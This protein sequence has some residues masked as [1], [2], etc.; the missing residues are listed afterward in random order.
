MTMRLDI[1]TNDA[2]ELVRREHARELGAGVVVAIYRLAKLAQLHDLGNQAFIRQLEQTHQIIG[3]Y[4]LRSGSNVSVL[5]AEKATFVAGQLLKGN[6]GAY[7]AAAE[8]GALLERMGGSELHISRDITREDLNAFAEQVSLYHRTGN[9]SQIR[10]PPKMHLRRVADVARLRGIE[11]ESLTPDQR[12]VRAYASAVVIMRRFFEDLSASR[13]VLPRRIKRIAQSLVDLSDAATA[14]YLGVTEVRNANYDEA[15]RAVNTAI[16]AVSIARESTQERTTLAQ[17]AMAAMMH[18]VARPRALAI[19]GAGGAPMPGMAGP[20]T[21][22]EDDEDRLPAG[23]AAV[24]TALGRVNEPSITRTVLTFEA[25]WLR[26]RT[27]LG[28]VYWGARAPTLQ[29]T[30]IAVARRYNDLLTPE[31]GLAPPTTDYAVAVLANELTDAQDRTVLRMLVSALGLLPIG[32]VVQL[33]TGE[34]AEVTRRTKGLGEKACVLVLADANGAPYPQP[35]EVDLAQDTRRTVVRVLSVDGWRKGLE[36]AAQALGPGPESDDDVIISVPPAPMPAVPP[37]PAAP[38]GMSPMSPPLSAGSN[39]SIAQQYADQ[40]ASWGAEEER[41]A[42][43]SGSSVEHP[44]S[45]SMPSLGSSPSAVAEAMGRMINDSLRPPAIPPRETER[46]DRTVFQPKGPDDAPAPR[47]TTSPAREAT[48]RGNL[49]ATPLP[50]VLVYML[51]HALTGT[52]VFERSSRGVSDDMIFFVNGVPAKIRLGE[53]VALLGE[54]LVEDGALEARALDQAVEGARRLGILLGEYLVGHDLVSRE[55]LAWGLEGQLLRKI[56]HVANLAPEI[57]YAYYRDVDLL[58]GWGG[59][60]AVS[61]PL[62][63]IL[64]SVRHWTDRARVRATLN[65]I[66]KHP[67]ALH[68]DSDLTNLAVIAEEQKVLDAVRAEAM[69]LPQL[70]QRSFADDEVVSS[71]VYSL[72]VTRQFA[73]KGQKKGPMAAR[74]AAWRS[75]HPPPGSG[76]TPSSKAPSGQASSGPASPSAPMASG[77]RPAIPMPATPAKPAVAGAPSA[78]EAPRTPN[79]GAPNKAMPPSAQMRAAPASAGA[80]RAPSPAIRPAQGPGARPVAPQIRPISVKKPTMV[81]IDPGAPAEARG[82]G[83]VSTRSPAPPKPEPADDAKTIARPAPALKDMLAARAGGAPS[84]GT[85][86]PTP[87]NRPPAVPPVRSGQAGA[88]LPPPPGAKSSQNHPPPVPPVPPVPRQSGSGVHPPKPLPPPEVRITKA[89][90]AASPP[91]KVATTVKGIAPAPASD[92]AFS[93]DVTGKRQ[94][95]DV[96]SVVRAN[97]DAD[98]TG[99]SDVSAAMAI[100]IGDDGLADAEAALEAMS[101]FRLAEGALQRNDIATAEQLA[102]KAVAGDP[103]Q[104]DY[105]TLL[106]WIRALAGGQ[107]PTDEAIR[108]M[109]KVLIEDPSNEK[110]L[111]YRGK[112]LVRTNR[113]PE[114]LNDFTELLSANPHHREAQAEV[115][116]LKGKVPGA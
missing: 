68:P 106:A 11:L 51:D 114:A 55:A 66:G 103:T 92:D 21:L 87:A 8:L 9:A 115:R 111:F 107:Q 84:A 74:G 112:L 39:R 3:E 48:A 113:F 81:G 102:K 59:E 2:G 42:S 16:L 64:A 60:V 108:T 49:A 52:V 80:L 86:K 25:L 12:I 38:T 4:C 5:F 23:T 37:P 33:S 31:P 56:A 44:A 83:P 72:A 6:R 57:E 40:Y 75:V 98:A 63:P 41:S 24:L 96:A 89:T 20:T 18:D 22:S 19:V 14:S 99:P 71:L 70:L 93:D 61:H 54:V 79:A 100:E 69:P 77:S 104:A 34:V 10:V 110:A 50:H 53:S 35:L 91:S 78:A 58:E 95:V 97:D 67:L 7:D 65:R 43:G 30:I 28:P 36:G 26:R 46:P 88:P 82:E 32:T 1:V 90:G 105:I 47:L 94:P 101:S 76:S 29:A 17:I 15:G 85:A 45:A 13:Y 73:F 109:S 62:N 27:W 116:A